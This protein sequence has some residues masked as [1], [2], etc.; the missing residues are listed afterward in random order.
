[1]TMLYLMSLLK[2]AINRTPKLTM[3]FDQ[4]EMG[5]NEILMFTPNDK[6]EIEYYKITIERF[7]K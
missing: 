1:M 2:S 6:A 7:R 5:K 4:S 3:A